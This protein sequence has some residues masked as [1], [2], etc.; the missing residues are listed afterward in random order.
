MAW[1]ILRLQM[2][3]QPPILRIAANVL[4]KQLRIA[5]KR[6]SSSLGVGRDANNS[7]LLK[8]ILLQNIHRQ[9]LGPELI[10]WYY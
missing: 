7:S 1:S 5:H 6:W 8:H 4:N 2:E 9:S 3:E 10:L